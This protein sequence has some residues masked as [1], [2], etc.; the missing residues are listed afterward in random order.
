MSA[1]GFTI[2]EMLLATVL[3]MAVTGA[4]FG[5]LNPSQG[6]YQTQPEMSDLQQRLRVSVQVLYRDLVMAGAGTYQGANAGPLHNVLAPVMPYR[7]GGSIDDPTSG[8]WY[9]EDAITLRYVPTTTAQ[10]TVAT[11]MTAGLHSFSIQLQGCTAAVAAT[12]SSYCGFVIGMPVLVFDSRGNAD[13]LTVTAINPALT[14]PQIQIDHAGAL[15]VSYTAG[16][17]AVA[18]LTQRTYYLKVDDET[19][20]SQLRQFD[21]DNTD[22][23]V[24]D[25]V[26]KLLFEYYGEGA[27]PR[28]LPNV[29]L[30]SLKGPWT[31][32]GPKPPSLGDANAP[33]PD[34]ENCL[35]LVGNNG[36]HEPR[37]A[38]LGGGVSQVKLDAGILNGDDEG[39][40]CADETKAMRFDADLLRIRRIGVTLRVQTALASLRGPAGVLF[41]NG[42]SATDG[43]RYVPDQEIRFDVTPRNMNLG[44]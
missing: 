17:T 16:Q 29:V 43:K 44:R 6:L 28:V 7:V 24:V 23:P 14:P 11:N 1:S 22:L 27:P 38:T 18:R 3:T 36:L 5:M 10:A 9:R 12:A 25:N 37:L 42:G 13:Q 4:I 26:V 19:Q 39:P 33:W 40:W 15:S 21:G 35:F 32:Y 2:I 41:A 20:T 8:R 34:G 30:S 31:T